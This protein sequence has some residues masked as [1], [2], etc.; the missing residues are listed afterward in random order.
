[1]LEH[2]ICNFK[3]IIIKLWKNSINRRPFRH[4]NHLLLK[5]I[6]KQWHVSIFENKKSFNQ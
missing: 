3:M 6:K 1:M 4:E 2:T 5:K